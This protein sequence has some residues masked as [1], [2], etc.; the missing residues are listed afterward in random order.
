MWSDWTAPS[1]TTPRR[2]RV[3]VS[4]YVGM[5]RIEGAIVDACLRESKEVFLAVARGKCAAPNHAVWSYF[6]GVN[7]QEQYRFVL[8]EHNNVS[9]VAYA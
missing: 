8:F 4:C 3:R 9:I 5:R 7:A 6:M 1:F 2:G